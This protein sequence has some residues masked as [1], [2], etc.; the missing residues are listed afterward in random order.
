MGYVATHRRP[1]LV[2]DLTRDSHLPSQ[3]RRASYQTNSF[4]IIPLTGQKFWGVI[5]LADREDGQSFRPPGPVSGLAHGP[6]P[7][8]DP[9]SPGGTPEE[10]CRCPSPTAWVSEAI[11]MGH[12]LSGPGPQGAAV[13]SGPGAVDGPGKAKRWWERNFFPHLGLS[14]QGPG[15]AGGSLPP[16]P[17]QP[18]TPGIRLL[19][20][21]FPG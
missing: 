11:P 20:G 10:V 14:H 16:G 8:G 2:P 5:N 12:G 17:G 18:G 19:E 15:K 3:P 7:G 6:A 1:L 4:M 13:Q 21:L 9:G